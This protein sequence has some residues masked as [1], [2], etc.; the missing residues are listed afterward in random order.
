MILIRCQRLHVFSQRGRRR[1]E[2][3]SS[4]AAFAAYHLGVR[5]V[6]I[7]DGGWQAWERA[8]YE[9]EEGW[10]EKPGVS[11]IVGG[12]EAA[13]EGELSAQS[14]RST[15]S[16]GQTEYPERR[17]ALVS[18]PA[19]VKTFMVERENPVLVSIRSYKEYIGNNQGS[20]WNRG[21]GEIVGAVFGGDDKLLNEEGHLANPDAYLPDWAGRGITPDRSVLLYCGTSWRASTAFFILKELGWN[22]VYM[23]DGSWHKWH[24]AHDEDPSAFP[25]QFGVPGS[26]DYEIVSE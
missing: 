23:F 9:Q 20:S 8:G 13:A 25:V 6:K 4:R 2:N 5:D 16:F 24:E 11:G 19:D 12:A 10:N 14:A 18:T 3:S 21:S 15:Q 7:L 17:G 22:Q 26:E 1:R